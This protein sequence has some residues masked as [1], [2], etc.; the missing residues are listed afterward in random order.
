MRDP[1]RLDTLR[2]HSDWENMS[3]ESM[4]SQEMEK[5]DELEDLG[6]RIADINAAGDGR[7]DRDPDGSSEV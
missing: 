6:V 1:R 2:V 3:S 5:I 7:L 4:D